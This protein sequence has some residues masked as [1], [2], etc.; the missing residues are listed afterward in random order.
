MPF[1]IC[2]C[3]ESDL[4]ARQRN[5]EEQAHMAPQRQSS[6]MLHRK[7]TM[8][9]SGPVYAEAISMI[10]IIVVIMLTSV[11]AVHTVEEPEEV[12]LLRDSRSQGIQTCLATNT[13][14]TRLQN[15]RSSFIAR[16]LFPGALWQR[17]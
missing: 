9:R 8:Q 12:N 7:H 13:A 17:S 11:A 15:C 16:V 14:A 10:T 5:E 2:L 6:S 4:E 1:H 3:I